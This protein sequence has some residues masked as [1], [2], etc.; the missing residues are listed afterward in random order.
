M[1]APSRL[2]GAAGRGLAAGPRRGGDRV[3]G[4]LG[5]EPLISFGGV[6]PLVEPFINFARFPQRG[7]LPMGR[8]IQDVDLEEFAERL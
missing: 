4:E 1:R 8:L 2:G 3:V 6:G 5:N 7:R